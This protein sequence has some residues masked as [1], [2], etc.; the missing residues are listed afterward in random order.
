[1]KK[2]I[3]ILVLIFSASSFAQVK[4]TVTDSKGKPIAFANVYV[5]DTYISTTSNE[6]GK[7]ELNVKIPGTYIILF[8][9]LGYK[10]EKKVIEFDKMAISVDA[11][12]Q[13]EEIQLQD[14]AI[15]NKVNPAIAIIKN[16]IAS[17]KENTK[18][19]DK[20][21]ADFYSR[22][23]FRVKNLPKTIL[24]QKL[25]FF[26]EMIDSTR[27][28]IL[29]LSETV[30]KITF[31]KPDKMKETI[32]ASK[33]SGN[34]NGY[35]F[36]NAAMV[37][38]DFYEN[39]LDFNVKVVSPIA[40]NA[41][42]YYKYKF[43][44]SFVDENNK[45]IDKIKVTAKRETEPAMNGYI[46][47]VDDTWAIYA[48]ELSIKGSQMQNP[49]MNT[50]TLKQNYSYNSK[51]KIWAKNTQTVDFDFGMLGININGRFTYVYSNFDFPEKLEK[52]TFTNEV[53]KFE[54]NA[55]KKEDPFWNTIRPVPLTLEESTDY[56]KKDVLQT[57]KKSKTY[58][59]SI[60]SK[61]NKFRVFDVIS[62]YN[63]SNSFKKWS[64]NYDG[65]LMKTSFNTVQGWKTQ[66]GVSYT[67]RNEEKRT[68]TRIG[69]NFDYGFSEN[70]LRATG[71]YFRKFNNINNA[72][73]YVN[74]GSS[75]NQF[76]GNNPISSMLNTFSSLVFKNNFM[77][78]YEKNFVAAN[79]GREIVNGLNMNFNLD[80]SERK[81]LC[82]TTDQSFTKSENV[83]SSNNPLLPNDFETPAFEK[84]NLIKSNV[85]AVI[86]FGQHYWT[87]PD[88]KFNIGNDS[89][90]TV[91]LGYE[92]TF[93]ATDKKYEYTLLSARVQQDF[94]LGNKGDMKINLRGGKFFN[95]DNIS[96]VDYKHFNG[97]QTHVSGGESYTNQ[98]NNLPY[99]S[100]STNNS[101]FETHIE[102]N[103]QGF[104]MNKIPL[105]NKLQSQLV[106]GF[107]NLAI[108]DRKP[109]QEFSVGLDNLG[110]GK[111][112]LFRLDYVRSYQNG[113]QGDAIIFGLKILN[114]LE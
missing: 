12:L 44:G 114:A 1:M 109:Y 81:P 54:A 64:I 86:K 14:V 105:L 30:S 41:F 111:A 76:N 104:I 35:S 24:G 38:Y 31:Q 70:K 79:F 68:F 25:D 26:D 89:Y 10:T 11:T 92:K 107:H 2:A 23:I 55:N 73:L 18:K 32:I 15:S 40:D 17:K 90:P 67:K 52:K 37:N 43:D 84:H 22:G 56:L 98:F 66:A 33:V 28:G 16:A 77:K 80:Y 21:N 93:S 5:K 95:A 42:N 63:Y 102:H 59:D 113:Y 75:V 45:I 100:A 46:Y 9:Y 53:L 91:S 110:V 51:N 88:G 78:L 20:Y 82:N 50:L 65:P 47:I 60:D 112:R 6:Q 7:Y 49:A 3:L 4:G 87:R 72:I 106:L 39:Y 85:V 34:D 8:K 103:D 101:Y 69:S 19:T 13:V 48:A 74:G 96:F 58:L 61:R 83:Y 62:G 99:Y 29:Y 97:N 57:K 36:N 94:T 71:S 27:S 108:P